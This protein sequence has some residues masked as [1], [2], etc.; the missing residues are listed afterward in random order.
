MLLSPCC[1]CFFVSRMPSS[2]FLFQVLLHQ[3]RS[4]R[5]KRLSCVLSWCSMTFVHC[6][7]KHGSCPGSG[8]ARFCKLSGWELVNL[9]ALHSDFPSGLWPVQLD[10]QSGTRHFYINMDE[11]DRVCVFFLKGAAR[12]LLFIYGRAWSSVFLVELHHFYIFM[13]E[14][15]QEPFSS[16]WAT[17]LLY[18]C[19]TRFMSEF[20]QVCF[21]R[22]LI[23]MGCC[24]TECVWQVQHL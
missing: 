16:G 11:L 17:S 15:D 12:S 23:K 20:E 22:S 6:T 1:L 8:P 7:N 9:S 18:S 3:N 10:R 2:L 14:L 24:L 21:C 5:W 19:W 13:A 4:R